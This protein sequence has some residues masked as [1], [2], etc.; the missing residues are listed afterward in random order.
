V[1]GIVGFANSERGKNLSFGFDSTTK[2][3]A[4]HKLD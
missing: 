4:K 2:F 3:L 1:E